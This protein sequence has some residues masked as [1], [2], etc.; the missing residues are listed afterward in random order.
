MPDLSHICDLISN[1]KS[2]NPLSEARD[3]T[4][5]LMDT[6]HVLNPLSHN[7]NFLSLLFYLGHLPCVQKVYM[8]INLLVFLLLSIFYY[9]VSAK[10]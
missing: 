8:S 3:G 5:I 6:S 4:C 1:S 9:G 2:L 7:R 10:N